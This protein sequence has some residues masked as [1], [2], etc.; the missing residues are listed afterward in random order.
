MINDIIRILVSFVFVTFYIFIN[1]EICTASHEKDDKDPITKIHPLHHNPKSGNIWKEP[2]SGIEFVWISAGC[3]QMGNI[4][5]DR[6]KYGH[7]KPVH[8][9]CLDGYWMG[10]F[11]VTNA[12]FRKYKPEHDSRNYMNNPLNEDN[13]PVVFISWN[14]AKNFTS[15]LTVKSNG[16][17]TFRLPTEAEWEYAC[18]AGTTTIRYWGQADGAACGHANIGD[19][20]VENE[21]A[22]IHLC[23]DGFFQTSPVGSFDPNQFGLYDM[24]GNVWEWCQDV[25]GKDTYKTHKRNNPIY[26]RFEIGIDFRVIRGGS[27]QSGPDSVRCAKRSYNPPT[28]RFD[29]LGFR[30]VMEP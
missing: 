28:N 27:W 30:I 1:S 21:P 12:Q 23:R 10:R 15:W 29:V 6:A 25:Y 22:D 14:G 16:G 7:E 20:L 5:S 17:H 8:E 19:T 9:V 24:L 13:Q 18:R 11:E 4:S 3:F 2:V 26:K